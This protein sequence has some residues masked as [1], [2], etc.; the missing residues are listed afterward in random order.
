[1]DPASESQEHKIVIHHHKAFKVFNMLK[2]K[3]QSAKSGSFPSFFGL[4]PYFPKIPSYVLT[5]GHK[6]PEQAQQEDHEEAIFNDFLIDSLIS[7]VL[8][9]LLE[10]VMLTIMAILYFGKD[11][12]SKLNYEQIEQDLQQGFLSSVLH[13]DKLVYLSIG[14]FVQ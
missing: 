2:L 14:Y 1:M 12:F 5:P 3:F 11:K 7:I 10:P 13:L 6:T 9:P 8:A 4:Y